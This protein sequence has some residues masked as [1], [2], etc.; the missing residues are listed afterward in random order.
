[1]KNAI[2]IFSI[3]TIIIISPN[4]SQ[5]EAHESDLVVRTATDVITYCEFYYR[6]FLF[7]G[8]TDFFILHPYAPNLRFCT[9]LYD[10]IAWLSK[11]PNREQILVSEIVRLIGDSQHV[12]ERHC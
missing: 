3:I 10:N 4:I 12:K 1:M 7:L 6:E 2:I 5:V 9:I 8:D 11:H